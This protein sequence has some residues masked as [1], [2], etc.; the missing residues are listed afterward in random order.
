MDEN[1]VKLFAI[2]VDMFLDN[3]SS[4]EENKLIGVFIDQIMKHD[5]NKKS[6]DGALV[7]TSMRITMGIGLSHY[8][9]NVILESLEAMQESNP[10]VS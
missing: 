10:D 6:K 3:T 8:I 7:N 2:M 5:I 1:K 9:D 4:Y